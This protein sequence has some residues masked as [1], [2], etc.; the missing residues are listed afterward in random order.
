M[1]AREAFGGHRMALGSF[2]NI[3]VTGGRGGGYLAKGAHLLWL[4][5]V[6]DAGAL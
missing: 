4:L 6:L 3:G 2:W 1:R 5:C